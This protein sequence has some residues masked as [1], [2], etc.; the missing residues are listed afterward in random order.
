M[1]EA[2]LLRFDA[3]LMSFGGP[4][5][6]QER[7]TQEFPARSMLAGLIAN[8]LGYEHR[9]AAETQRLQERLRFAA[10]RDRAGA[11]LED[12]QTVDLGQSFLVDSGW[13]TWRRPETRKGGPARAET[14][15]R[16]RHHFADA[17]YTVAITLEPPTEAPTLLDLERA[18]QM[19]ARPLFLGRKACLPASP[20]FLG[21]SQAEGLRLLLEA[22]PRITRRGDTGN[23]SAWWPAEEGGDETTSQLVP[24]HDDRD[25]ANQIHAG[26]RLLWQGLVDPTEPAD[27]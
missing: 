21:R 25:W 17:V 4:A 20:I 27:E 2:L 3:P 14:H 26:R 23:L 13:T 9:H 22:T 12:Y 7:V 11:L 19:P 6:D 18:L 24:V 10:R 16:A 1:I 5:V 15:I 8:A